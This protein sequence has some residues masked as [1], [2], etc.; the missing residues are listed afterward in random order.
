[1]RMLLLLAAAILSCGIL[2]LAYLSLSEQI[3]ILLYT[4]ISSGIS[5]LLIFAL[6]HFIYLYISKKK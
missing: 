5:I 6:F 3:G 2:C 4:I 1:M